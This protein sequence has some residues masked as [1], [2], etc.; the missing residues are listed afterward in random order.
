[1][2]ISDI[3]EEV[4]SNLV[5]GTFTHRTQYLPD[6]CSSVKQ[7]YPQIP[8]IVHYE[9]QELNKNFEALRLKFKK[10]GKRFW[11]FLDDDTRFVND[12]VIE[13]SLEFLLRKGY[14][15]VG[16]YST[17][18]PNYVATKQDLVEEEVG[19]VPGYFQLVDSKLVGDLEGDLNLPYSNF[20]TDI[21]Y[22]L[23]VHAKGYKIGITADYVWHNNN[24]LK[25]PSARREKNFPYL[26]E[27][28][29]VYYRFYDIFYRYVV[30]ITPCD[31]EGITVTNPGVFWK[32]KKVVNG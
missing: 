13:T 7:F 30:G 9:K 18:F 24:Y 10:S 4:K 26:K 6:L 1:M 28:W 16:C 23:G 25:S 8:F 3:R 29:G 11:L 22:C 12:T 20:H 32:E 21:D 31:M 2:D 14:G 5:M 15:M 19:W 27:K 17:Y